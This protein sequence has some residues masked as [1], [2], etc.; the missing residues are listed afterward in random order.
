MDTALL[1]RFAAAY[2]VLPKRVAA[3]DDDVAGLHQLRQRI[4]RGL[5]DLARR[6]HDPGGSRPLELADEIFQGAGADRTVGRDGW[7]GLRVLVKNDR[8]MSVLH[9]PADD[10]AAHPPQAN[11]AELHWHPLLLLEHDLIRNRYPLFGI[12]L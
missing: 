10:I 5:G 12:M 11:H 1:Q 2:V 9:Q 6:E 4:D 3:V 7:D 8:G